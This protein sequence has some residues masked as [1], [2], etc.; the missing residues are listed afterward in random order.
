MIFASPK[1]PRHTEPA[2]KSSEKQWEQI[3]NDPPDQPRQKQPPN[4]FQKNKQTNSKTQGGKCVK[5]K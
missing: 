2:T 1:H 5:Q 4:Q 3:T